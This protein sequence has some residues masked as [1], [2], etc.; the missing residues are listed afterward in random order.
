MKHQPAVAVPPS[1]DQKCTAATDE[2]VSPPPHVTDR[3]KAWDT[4]L[5]ATPNTG[6]MQSSWWAD[7]RATVGFE[8]FG[9][10]L[11]DRNGVVGGAMVQKFSCTPES[12]FYY[13]QDGPVLPDNEAMAEEVLGAVLEEIE[14]HRKGEQQTISHLRMEPRWQAIPGFLSG[15]CPPNFN[16]RFREPR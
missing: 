10:V 8:H 14:F 3:W 5:E 6:F 13:I 16:D 2:P 1:I 4:F 15:F 9:A 12:S 11:K 7:F